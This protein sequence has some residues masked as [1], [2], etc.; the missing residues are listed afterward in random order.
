MHRCQTVFACGSSALVGVE[1]EGGTAAWVVGTLEVPKCRDT[2]CLSHRS[3]GPIRVCF[4]SLCQLV[5]RRPLWL[6][7]LHCSTCSC[8]ERAPFLGVLLCYS[9]HQAHKGAP[10]LGS[11][12]VVWYVRHLIGHPGWGPT[13]LF[14]HVRHLNGFLDGVLL[15]CSTCQVLDG[16]ASLLFSYQC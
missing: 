16:L 5:I 3:Y 6:D 11:Y 2:D 7:F 9:S 13:V 12:S 10:W 15:C 4:S 14:W 8:T 1:C